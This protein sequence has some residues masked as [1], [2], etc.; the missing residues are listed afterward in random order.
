MLGSVPLDVPSPLM[1]NLA[2]QMPMCHFHAT[3]L[4][5]PGV[6]LLFLSALLDVFLRSVGRNFPLAVN[7]ETDV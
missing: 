4:L 7:S 3:L 5:P 6:L 2:V 1:R